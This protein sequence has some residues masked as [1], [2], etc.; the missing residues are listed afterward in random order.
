MGHK[1]KELMF[2]SMI[3]ARVRTISLAISIRSG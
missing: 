1:R 3:R 2:Y